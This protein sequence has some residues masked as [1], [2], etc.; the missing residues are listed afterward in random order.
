[1]GGRDRA[2]GGEAD[3]SVNGENNSASETP[4]V[5]AS[6]S[7]FTSEMFCSPRSIEPT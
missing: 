1:M 7:M 6:F 3:L 2:Q 5:A 4:R